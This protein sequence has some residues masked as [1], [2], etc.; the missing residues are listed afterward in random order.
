MRGKCWSSSALS[1]FGADHSGAVWGASRIG[2]LRAWARGKAPFRLGRSLAPCS[3]ASRFRCHAQ[4]DRRSETAA[5]TC[6]QKTYSAGSPNSITRQRS[7]SVSP[8]RDIVNC[9]DFSLLE[10]GTPAAVRP[11][12]RPTTGVPAFRAWVRR[13]P[14]PVS[15]CAS[16]Y[17]CA[18]ERGP[19]RRASRA[20][21]DVGI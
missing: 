10:T 13:L 3:V 5:L 7:I 19:F 20:E 11:S 4:R 12:V 1:D 15:G 2:L 16:S 18:C 8:S 9:M 6:A 17:F 21:R 14:S